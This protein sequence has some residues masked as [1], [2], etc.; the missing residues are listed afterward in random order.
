DKHRNYTCRV[1]DEQIGNDPGKY[2]VDH[3]DE[4]QDDEQKE[5]LCSLSNQPVRNGSDGLPLVPDRQCQRPEI[6]DTCRKN[7]P[8]YYPQKCG[9]P[10]PINGNCRPEYRGRSGDRRKVV[11]PQ[12][13]FVCRDKVNAVLVL[14]GRCDIIRIET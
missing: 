5:H 14:V 1:L 12:N 13:K 4:D 2:C 3:Q 9:Q 11:S 10:S 7:R 6:M 8:Q